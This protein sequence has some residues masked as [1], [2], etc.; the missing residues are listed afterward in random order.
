MSAEVAHGAHGAHEDHLNH[1]FM[2]REQQDDSYKVGMWTFLVTEI[3]F[4]GALFLSYTVYRTKYP[5]AFH[6]AHLHLNVVLGAFNTT[7][8]LFSSFTMALG[9]RA[10]QL[11]EKKGVLRFLAITILCAFTFLVVKGFEYKDK[12]DHH[13]V[14]GPFYHFEPVEEGHGTPAL[15]A[16]SVETPNRSEGL[17]SALP[18]SLNNRT[19]LFFCLYFG[20]TGLHAFHV[21]VGIFVLG[22]L[23]IMTKNNHPS[24]QY[25]MPTELAGLYWH[26]VDIVWIFLFPL[27][28]LVG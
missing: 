1:Q 6:S 15:S 9:V 2:D 14:P 23:Y 3:M 17:S 21:L 22:T 28:Y 16:A 25:F 10:A 4:F 12:W 13:L 19:E 27:L 8:L 20:M 11:G 5:E 7:V 24:V 18:S 26:F